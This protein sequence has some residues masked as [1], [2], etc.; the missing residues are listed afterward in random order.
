MD[1]KSPQHAQAISPAAE[2]E[3]YEE[4]FADASERWA[5]A[6]GYRSLED[7]ERAAMQRR[8]IPYP[9][10]WERHDGVLRAVRSYSNGRRGYY[11]ASGAFVDTP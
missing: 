6:T 9:V 2:E 7:A 1:W 11:D 8:A 5:A 10:T 4:G 3:R